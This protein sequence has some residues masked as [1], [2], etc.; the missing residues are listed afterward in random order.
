MSEVPKEDDKTEKKSKEEEI[1]FDAVDLML[2]GNLQAQINYSMVKGI[3]SALDEKAQI[4]IQA[5]ESFEPQEDETFAQV[6]MPEIEAM[7]QAVTEGCVN[8]SKIRFW[9]ACETAEIAWE[10]SKDL[11]GKVIGKMPYGNPLEKPRE[12]N[13]L[14]A[15]LKQI[16][17]WLREVHSLH[18]K[19]GMGWVSPY[20]CPEDGQQAY[21][22]RL[23]CI[24]KIANIISSVEKNF[25]F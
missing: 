14:L 17:D 1:S 24:N 5:E 3:A 20:G 18:E 10:E 13:R 15:N 2:E 19:N 16:E 7:A 6:A 22:N 12:G 9:E 23:I 4:L 8:F 25:D 21:D 11:E